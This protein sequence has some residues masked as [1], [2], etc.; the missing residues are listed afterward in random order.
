MKLKTEAH[1]KNQIEKILNKYSKVWY[2]MPPAGVFGKKGISDYIGCANGT[3][4]AIEAKA[5]DVKES[6]LSGMQKLQLKKM[7]KAGGY[8]FNVY[9]EATLEDLD[10]FLKRMICVLEPKVL[11]IILDNKK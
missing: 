1:V 10:A 6:G 2:F 4:F 9:D 3:F 7:S 5:P 8:A 11:D